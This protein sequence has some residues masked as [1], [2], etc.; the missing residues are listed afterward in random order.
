MT[1]ITYHFE[2]RRGDTGPS[3]SAEFTLAI[4]TAPLLKERVRDIDAEL[5]KDQFRDTKAQLLNVKEAIDVNFEDFETGQAL[6]Q[7]DTPVSIDVHLL[8]NR[9]GAR[10]DE[11]I[12]QRAVAVGGGGGGGQG[13]VRSLR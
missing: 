10:C 6:K 8:E 9:A 3:R 5:L 13:T 1:A 12:A 11:E 4:T 2:Q 7:R